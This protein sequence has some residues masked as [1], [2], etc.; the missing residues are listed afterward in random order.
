MTC[1]NLFTHQLP[2]ASDEATPEILRQY[3]Q[4]A[5]VVVP[6]WDGVPRD[7]IKGTVVAWLSEI[8]SVYGE[9]LDLSPLDTEDHTGID[10]IVE[11]RMMRPDM[12]VYGIEVP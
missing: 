5:D 12:P 10:P 1:D 2:R 3:P 6:D 4:L 9:T 8:E 7:E 11:A